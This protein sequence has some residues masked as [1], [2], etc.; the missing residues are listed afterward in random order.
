M[1]DLKKSNGII[2]GASGLIG[3]K[4]AYE[5][6]L[7]GSKLI[8]HGKSKK[9]LLE[10]D[11]NLRKK[12]IKQTFLH[13]EITKPE[14][15][16]ELSSLVTSRFD[17][18][19]FIFNLVCKFDRLSPLTHFSHV[20]WNNLIEININSHWRIIKELEPILKKTKNSK[21]IFLN[22]NSISTNKAYHNIL[23]ISKSAVESL[24]KV[25]AQENKN[26]NMDIKIIE[27]PLLFG[28][29][30]SKISNSEFQE[31]KV[32]ETIIKIIEESFFNK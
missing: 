31:K 12:G 2:F 15:F 7:L 18:L 24:A 26:L 16:S 17:K 19:N 10:I 22:N 14:F 11:N 4:L 28:G 9:K 27:I 8:L 32:D 5:I 1:L 29:I 23:S 30:T 3:S 21:V 6:S 20:E 13:G 25:Y